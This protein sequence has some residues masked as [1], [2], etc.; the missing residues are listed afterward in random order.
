VTKPPLPISYGTHHSK[1]FLLVFPRGVRLIVHT[2]NLIFCDINNKSQGVF[3]QDFPRKGPGS[4]PSSD[5]EVALASY[6]ATLQLPG[7]AGAAT[8]AAVRD[9]DFSSARAALVASTPGRHVGEALHMQGHMRVRRLLRG[10]AFP[11]A[12]A[13]APIACQFSSLGS[14]TEQW[15]RD[16]FG[17]SLSAGRISGAAPSTSG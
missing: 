3:A 13:G 14:L 9:H 17:A 8:L 7:T 1:F 12:F 10:E 2:A 15:L 5:F 4:A 16:E 11:D 6:L